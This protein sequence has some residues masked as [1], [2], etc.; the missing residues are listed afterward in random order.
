MRWSCACC[1]VCKRGDHQYTH[2]QAALQSNE[3]R[4]ASCEVRRFGTVCRLRL[5]RPSVLAAH[6]TRRS[7]Y[8]ARHWRSSCRTLVFHR[9]G[10]SGSGACRIVH[11][12]RPVL[13][14]Y[15]SRKPFDRPQ[16]SARPGVFGRSPG[17]QVAECRWLQRR[18]VL[19][20]TVVFGGASSALPTAKGQVFLGACGV[21]VT[22]HSDSSRPSRPLS[23]FRAAPTRC[24][25]PPRPR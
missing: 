17:R 5:G 4:F 15:R 12:A 23:G 14:A 13:Y 3:S 7:S 18:S 25:P 21:T 2:R 6:K 1:I 20:G 10:Y 24:L 22:A 8:C 19:G 16:E 11:R 9:V